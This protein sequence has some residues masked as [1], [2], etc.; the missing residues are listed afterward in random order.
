MYTAQ[1]KQSVE[2]EILHLEEELRRGKERLSELRRKVPHHEIEDH[3]VKSSIGVDVKLSQLFGSKSEM[4]VIHNMGRS[5]S[6]CTMWADGFNG[7]LKHLENRVACVLESPEDPERM[8]E[9]AVD[10]GWTFTIVSSKGTRMRRELGF[11][12]ED[13]ADWPGISA[14]FKSS[15]GKIHQVANASFGPGDN[16]CV[17]WDIF[18]LLPKAMA[19]WDAKHYYSNIR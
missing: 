10:R 3:L 13:G 1:D 8:R 17:V 16:Y 4:I 6:Y 9:F 11:V 12:G 18:D 5:C 19:T 2:Q 15:D 14:L 7:I